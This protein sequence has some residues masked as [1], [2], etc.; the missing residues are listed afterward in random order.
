MLPSEH[1]P[2]TTFVDHRQFADT[3]HTAWAEPQ[4]VSCIV[5][6][7]V[8]DRW[9]QSKQGY[10]SLSLL[11]AAVLMVVHSMHASVLSGWPGVCAL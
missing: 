8:L 11:Y 1:L 4:H 9:M 3:L 2:G 5:A 6:I 7:T 10:I